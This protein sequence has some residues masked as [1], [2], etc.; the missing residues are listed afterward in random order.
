MKTYKI[1]QTIDK[2]IYPIESKIDE[3]K[4]SNQNYLKQIFNIYL[5][6]FV[7]AM[8]TTFISGS[9]ISTG[10]ENTESN[11]NLTFL[12]SLL[13][14]WWGKTLCILIVFVVFV[15]VIFAICKLLSFIA[16]RTDN[17]GTSDKRTQI[18]KE[19]YK[20]LVPEI[21]TGASLFE[22]AYEIESSTKE[23][24]IGE[25]AEEII[26][27]E[28]EKIHLEELADG[29]TVSDKA[30]LYY[31]ESFYHFKLV[32]QRFEDLKLIE[33]KDSDRPNLKKLY[34]IIGLDALKKTVSFSQHCVK[35]VCKRICD[36]EETKIC[37]K[38]NDFVRK[39]K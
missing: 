17:K 32:A 36:A 21:I 6:V 35:E 30:I 27:L 38:F 11:D 10:T 37:D 12:E 5:P 16:G 24:S 13:V 1:S 4:E 3:L 22:R 2:N 7:S 31:Y 29:H 14:P 18:A 23:L 9:I 33:Y 20:V 15:F 34:E 39:L 28:A 25:E 26:D 19:F 8:L